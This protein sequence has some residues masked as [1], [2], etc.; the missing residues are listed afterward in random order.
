MK[1]AMEVHKGVGPADR[2]GTPQCG[3]SMEVMGVGSPQGEGVKLKAGVC[4]QGQT[5]E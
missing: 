4:Q 1:Q 3:V 2:L 5:G